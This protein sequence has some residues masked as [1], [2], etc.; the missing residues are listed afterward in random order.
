M[1]ALKF[2]AQSL[3]KGICDLLKTKNARNIRTR[4]SYLYSTFNI[5]LSLSELRL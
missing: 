1:S 5:A 4:L 3:G 2:T